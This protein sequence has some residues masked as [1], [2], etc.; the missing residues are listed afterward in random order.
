MASP[1]PGHGSASAKLSGGELLRVES[2]TASSAA[3]CIC[4]DK[5]TGRKSAF[6]VLLLF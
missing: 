4:E 5:W 2:C 3:L 1:P 6:A